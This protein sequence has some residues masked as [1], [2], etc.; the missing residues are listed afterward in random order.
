LV[1]QNTVACYPSESVSS[2]SDFFD[3]GA[4]RYRVGFDA[5]TV[6]STCDHVVG[7]DDIADGSIAM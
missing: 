3:Y 2:V 7:D 6:Y 4:C 5:N 1:N